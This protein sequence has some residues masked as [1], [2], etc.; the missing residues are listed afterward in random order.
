MKDYFTFPFFNIYVG[1]APNDNNT[2]H[3]QKYIQVSAITNGVSL[4]EL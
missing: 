4:E 1:S 2:G 3:Q